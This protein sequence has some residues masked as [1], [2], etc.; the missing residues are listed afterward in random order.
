MLGIPNNINE[1]L[2]SL[3]EDEPAQDQD[4]KN[5]EETEKDSTGLKAMT[6][7]LSMHIDGREDRCCHCVPIAVSMV[8]VGMM[9]IGQT[10]Y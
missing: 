3:N 10:I 2:V 8:F 7:K 5:I 4:L 6:D 1:T 9:G